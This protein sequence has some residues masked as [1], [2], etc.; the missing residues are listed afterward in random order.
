MD[1]FSTFL[2]SR[3]KISIL[4]CQYRTHRNYLMHGDLYSMKRLLMSCPIFFILQR[5]E[6]DHQK[7][8][9]V[10]YVAQWIAQL[11]VVLKP[12]NSKFTMMRWLFLRFVWKKCLIATNYCPPFYCIGIKQYFYKFLC[13][14]FLVTSFKC[15]HWCLHQISRLVNGDGFKAFIAEDCRGGKHC[16]VIAGGDH[17]QQNVRLV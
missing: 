5:R 13:G 16:D 17:L 2:I 9:G 6:F 12:S 11:V 8:N 3:L 14:C 15:K 4:L 10:S 1:I 7:G